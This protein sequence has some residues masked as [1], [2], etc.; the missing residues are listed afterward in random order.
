MQI[1]SV[2][3]FDKTSL[4]ELLTEYRSTKMSKNNKYLVPKINTSAVLKYKQIKTLS[5]YK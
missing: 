1:L 2:S 3:S 5:G 4:K